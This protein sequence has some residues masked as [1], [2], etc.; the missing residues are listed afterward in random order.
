MAA[1]RVQLGLGL[2]LGRPG[3][4]VRL[5]VCRRLAHR[6]EQPGELRAKHLDSHEPPVAAA[7]GAEGA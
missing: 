3:H 4:P 7:V 6:P 5:E 1:A 2:G